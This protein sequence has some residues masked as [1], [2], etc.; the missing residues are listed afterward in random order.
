MSR[1]QKSRSYDSRNRRADAADTRKRILVASKNLFAKKGID[2]TTFREIALRAKVA[3]SYVY[4]LF[5]SKSGILVALM[6]ESL[7]G[8]SFKKAQLLLANA[9]TPIDQIRTTASIARSIYES[10]Q[11]DLAIL[12]G[13]S[14]FSSELKKADMKFEEIRYQMQ[15][16]RVEALFKS[17][18]AA[19]GLTKSTARDLLWLFTSREIYQKLVLERKWTPDQYEKWLTEALVRNLT[20]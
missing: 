8:G 11:L 2:G 13:L 17:K 12:R 3:E 7:F 14:G 6:E 19:K 4:T 20:S 15:E 18:V 5:Q 1:I 10:E 9:Q 16:L